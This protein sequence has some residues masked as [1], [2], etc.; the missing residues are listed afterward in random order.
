MIVMIPVTEDGQSDSRFGRAHSVA[1][2][3]VDGDQ[4]TDWQVH[5]VAWDVS[6]DQVEHG[7]HHATVMRFFVKQ[8][9][10]A[11]VVGDMGAGMAKMITSAKIAAFTTTPGDAKA[12]V[13]AAL[14]DPEGHA[15]RPPADGGKHGPLHLS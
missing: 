12:S 10:E 8:K 7:S 11:V 2:A 6:H 9:V 4:I 14:A 5:E 3:Q 13:L 15:W 1:V